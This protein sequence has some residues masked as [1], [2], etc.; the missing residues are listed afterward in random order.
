[1]FCSR[2]DA[3]GTESTSA[4]VDDDPHEG[5]GLNKMQSFVQM[6]QASKDRVEKGMYVLHTRERCM[7]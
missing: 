3:S 1:M 6:K 5:A 7:Y 4:A 2:V